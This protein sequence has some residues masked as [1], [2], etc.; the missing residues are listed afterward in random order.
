[1]KYARFSCR[2]HQRTHL[3]NAVRFLI[4]IGL[5][6]ALAGAANAETLV[7]PPY[8]S[9]TPWKK[10][11]DH[12]DAK[13]TWFE[14]IPAEQSENAIRDILAE[15]IFPTEKGADPSEF[16]RGWLKRMIDS[17]RDAK[18]NGPTA[19]A[20]NGF[21][22][23]YAQVY[24][25]DS[26]GTD[27]DILF[28]AIAGRDALYVVQR[29]FRRPTEP[30]EVAGMRNFGKDQGDA[31]KAALEAQNA[32]NDYLVSKVKLCA[33]ADNGSC[34]PGTAK[35]EQAD[36]WPVEGKTT[37]SEVRDKLG[38]PMM[39]NRS[40]PRHTGEYVLMFEGKDGTMYGFLFDKN[41]V[42]EHLRVY[43]RNPP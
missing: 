38:R 28:K 13:L 18:V 31:A 37:A 11:T 43:A 7:V 29:E 20:E 36:K 25:V 14:W 22:V 8:P 1:M 12:A 5:A 23:A 35:S 4:P 40:D 2:L 32:A 34:A 10:V 9:P 15:Q 30:G 41:D 3:G 39:E 19:G 16:T 42:L 17:C 24:C 27:V 26:K 33:N 21:S 6:I